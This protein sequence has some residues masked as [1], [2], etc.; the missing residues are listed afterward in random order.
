MQ[1]DL[2]N[3]DYPDYT[4]EHGFVLGQGKSQETLMQKDC[5]DAAGDDSGLNGSDV[6][7][8]EKR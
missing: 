2:F 4:E 6:N 1:D 3:E 7:R 8:D 5:G